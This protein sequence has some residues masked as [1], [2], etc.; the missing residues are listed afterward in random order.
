MSFLM[1][2][3]GGALGST[4]RYMVSL[5]FIGATWPLATLLVNV[6]GSLAIGALA[7]SAL[8]P[9][10]RLFWM[11]GVLGGFTTFSAFSLEAVALWERAVWQGVAYAAASLVLGLGAFGLGWVLARG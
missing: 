7:G 6:I 11:T 5:F 4:L 10:M 3:M 2:A 9:Q 8:S 1:V